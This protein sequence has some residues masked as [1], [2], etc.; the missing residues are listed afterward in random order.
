MKDILRVVLLTLVVLS[1]A[2][3]IYPFIHELGHFTACK[4][5]GAEVSKF[6]LFPAFVEC[7]VLGLSKQEI[8][9]IG[10]S[11]NLLP[12]IIMILYTLIIKPKNIY[13]IYTKVHSA[14]TCWL[15]WLLSLF[16]IIAIQLGYGD[17]NMVK[18]EDIAKIIIKYPDITIICLVLCV[19]M[20]I[21]CQFYMLN[22][23]TLIA[24]KEQLEALD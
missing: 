7:N 20:T 9:I 11:G 19:L 2:I 22:K 6:S 8:S 16:N 14:F 5:V 21:V 23:K 4:I 24:A 17:L 12:T 15:S 13:I 3:V 10:I 1:I 18:D